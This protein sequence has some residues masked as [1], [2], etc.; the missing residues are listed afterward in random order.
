VGPGRYEQDGC[1]VGRGNRYDHNRL[2]KGIV[3]NLLE[4]VVSRD[5]GEDTWDDLLAAA[6][7]DGAYTSLGSYP[8]EHL[9]RL[10]GAASETLRLPAQDVVRWF[11]REAL[12]ALATA[13]PAFFDPHTDTRSFVLTLNDIIHPEVRKLYPGADVPEFA[14]DTSSDDVLRMGYDS[15]RRMCAF[16]E[17]LI[18]GAA[19]HYGEQVAISQSSCMLR[20]DARCDLEMTFSPKATSRGDG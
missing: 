9:G 17:G 5:Y 12:P 13:Y 8:D 19:A 6:G 2:V 14:F 1:V 20:G 11:G 18:E 7:L 15:H 16:A 3:F 10:V 4:Q